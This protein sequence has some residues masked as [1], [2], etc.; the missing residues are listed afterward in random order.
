M[1]G[2][3]LKEIAALTAFGQD[4]TRD[5]EDD[6]FEDGT[7]AV[8]PGAGHDDG[9]GVGPGEWRVEGGKRQAEPAVRS[10]LR[11]AAGLAALE[12]EA[13]YRGRKASRQA[14]G[15]MGEEEEESG[16]DDDDEEEEESG[17]EGEEQDQE[18]ASGSG[19]RFGSEEEEA[20]TSSSAGASSGSGSGSDS[21][22]DMA[23]L[24]GDQQGMALL[25]KRS[26][27]AQLHKAE[28]AKRHR[29]MW[30]R[31]LEVRIL[32]QRLLGTG[33]R[34]PR[35][36]AHEAYCRAEPAVGEGL[37]GAASVLRGVLSQLVGLRR[38]QAAE[39]GEEEEGMSSEQGGKRRRVQ[40]TK[41]EF[42]GP[43]GG[44][45]DPWV[46]SAGD[47]DTCK[48]QWRQVLDAAHQRATLSAAVGKK[49]RVVNQGLWHQV[50]ASLADR[51]RS[52]RRSHLTRAQARAAGLFVG[53]GAEEGEE[54]EAEEGEPDEE[55]FDDA[56]LYQLL[57]RDYIQSV[58][59]AGGVDGLSAMAGG[60]GLS[61]RSKRKGVD[62]KASKGRKL[63]YAVHPKLEHFMFA[64]PAPPAP[65]DVDRLFASLPGSSVAVLGGLGRQGQELQ[66][67]ESD[68]E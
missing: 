6:V 23:R 13:R 40:E 30:N 1:K 10:K 64:V 51:T 59:P 53:V 41:P 65:M 52:L 7:S 67:G 56:E 48:A 63:R 18:Q 43:I 46:A 28:A 27:D 61:K 62:T 4:R 15:L 17:S 55:A 2:Q 57:L 8:A 14:L 49:F 32:L 37:D 66:A 60:G 39:L 29:D 47:Y 45:D 22:E 38:E 26:R 11:M 9:E 20:E 31:L 58:G 34:L 36:Q 42:T 54:Q 35:G 25:L 12:E 50:E 16:S 19:L 5:A 24:R 21:E 33:N 68:E 44:R 3:L